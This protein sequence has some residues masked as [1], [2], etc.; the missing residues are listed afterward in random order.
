MR[1]AITVLFMLLASSAAGQENVPTP[2]SGYSWVRLSPLRAMFLQPDGWH[3]KSEQ[4]ASARA[5]FISRE[6]IDEV[7]EFLVGLTINVLRP[8]ETATDAATRLMGQYMDRGEVLRM[9]EL[10]R[11]PMS[12]YVASIRKRGSGGPLMLHVMTIANPKTNVLYAIIF[13]APAKEWDA[14]WSIGETI[15]RNF[16]LDDED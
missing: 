5:F 3:F 13:E 8:Q 2:P 11:G 6:N 12:G 7:G 16:M 10:A 1:K 9:R 15:L 4:R 14:A